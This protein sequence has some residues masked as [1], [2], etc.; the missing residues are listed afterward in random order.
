VNEIIKLDVMKSPFNDMELTGSFMMC[1]MSRSYNTSSRG[2]S[3]IMHSTF[4]EL[5]V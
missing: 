2:E 5:I 1:G 4:S 3:Q